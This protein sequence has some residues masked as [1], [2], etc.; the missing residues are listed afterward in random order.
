M[1]K[2]QRDK[3]SP[4]PSSEKAS[5]VMS[6]IKGKNTKPELTL[7]KLLWREGLR[8]YRLHWKIPGSPDLVFTRKKIAIFVNGCYWHKCPK[9]NLPIPK[10]NSDFWENK[11]HKNVLRDEMKKKLLEDANWKVIIIWECDIKNAQ[12]PT[13]DLI[14]NELLNC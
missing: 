3:R 1:P 4:I 6:S 7:R 12:Q 5:R 14:K 9:C 8:G 13:I 11:F 10:S 2:Y